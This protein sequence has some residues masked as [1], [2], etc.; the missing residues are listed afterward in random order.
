MQNEKL[1]QQDLRQLSLVCDGCNKA[2]CDTPADF[3]ANVMDCSLDKIERQQEVIEKLLSDLSSAE[4][5]II[6]EQRLN[7]S[8]KNDLEDMEDDM[9][10][11]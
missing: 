9:R 1:H 8:L 2:G 6:K 4:L 10:N 3:D 11:M 7:E 5:L